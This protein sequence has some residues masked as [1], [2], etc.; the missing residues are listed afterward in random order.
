MEDSHVWLDWL[1]DD[2]P[3][4]TWE[5]RWSFYAVYDGHGGP[6]CA[7]FLRPMVHGRI[8]ATP[9]FAAGNL[10]EAMKIGFEEVRTAWGFQAA[11]LGVV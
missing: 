2:V 7:H 5:T 8:V 6:E 9:E 3:T 4:L 10:Q 11:N 1:R